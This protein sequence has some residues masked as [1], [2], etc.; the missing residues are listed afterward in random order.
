MDDLDGFEELELPAEEDESQDQEDEIVLAT[1][2][3]VEAGG[4]KIQIDGDEAAGDKIYRVNAQQM[5]AA[6][7][8]VK[9][10]KNS[11]TYIVEYV[12]GN[13]MARYPI[14]SGGSAGQVLAKNSATNYDV[15]WA[16]IGIP[17]GGNTGQVLAKSSNANYA[18]S[19][20]DAGHGLPTGGNAGQFLKKK[21]NSNYDTEWAEP[22]NYIPA[23]GTNGQ[24]L[25]KNGSTNYSLTWGSA[26]TVSELVNGNAK[27]SLSSSALAPNGNITLGSNLYPF[28]GCYIKGAVALAGSNGSLG[29]F[30]TTP[31][32]RRYVGSSG[33]L[34]TLISALQAY[35]LIQ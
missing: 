18:V 27:V 15:V 21:S 30:G 29:F 22:T 6:G 17:S 16:S 34:A 8:R 12:L 7:D 5:F 23:G 31:A 24:Y 20:V 2:A 19:W 26:P 9:I 4:V 25:V 13:P 28:N 33:T 11:G 35:G 1:I 14:P 10:E 32:S 3:S